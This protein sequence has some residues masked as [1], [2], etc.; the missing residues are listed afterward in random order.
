M[1]LNRLETAVHVKSSWCFISLQ[2]ETVSTLEHGLNSYLRTAEMVDSKTRIGLSIG[3]GRLK[4]LVSIDPHR[5]RDYST[6][7]LLPFFFFRNDCYRICLSET[8]GTDTSEVLNPWSFM[9]SARHL[10]EK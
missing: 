6:V 5:A 10:G 9:D 3:R 8:L 1:Q 2:Q 7:T 4:C